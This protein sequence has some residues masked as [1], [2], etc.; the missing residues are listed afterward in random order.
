MAGGS[1]RLFGM[2]SRIVVG[3]YAMAPPLTEY[4]KVS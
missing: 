2:A 3:E 1:A 4:L